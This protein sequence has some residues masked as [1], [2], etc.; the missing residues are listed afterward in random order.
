MEFVQG[1]VFNIN[2]FTDHFKRTKEEKELIKIQE[3]ISFNI[4]S[5]AEEKAFLQNRIEHNC[6]HDLL[7]ADI[8]RLKAAEIMQNYHIK[9][10]K[11]LFNSQHGG[12]L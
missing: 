8:Y 12:Q 11:Q 4:D 1:Q 5:I 9:Q 6:A 7:Q 10:A 2:K 3:Q